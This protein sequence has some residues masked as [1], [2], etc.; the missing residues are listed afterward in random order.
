MENHC[1]CR[2]RCEKGLKRSIH[3]HILNIYYVESIAT[4]GANIALYV[5]VGGGGGGGEGGGGGGE[6]GGGGSDKL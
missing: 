2:C 5:W 1:R 4:L 6:G 3:L